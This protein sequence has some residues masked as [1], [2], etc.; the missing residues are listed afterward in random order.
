MAAPTEM[1]NGEPESSSPFGLVL[2]FRVAHNPSRLDVK[3][4]DHFLE[5]D[6]WPHHCTFFLA[7]YFRV[8]LHLFAF[9]HASTNTPYSSAGRAHNRV[10]NSS[11]SMVIEEMFGGQH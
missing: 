5:A 8:R 6:F 11:W 9:M 1:R 7:D 4:G 2:N 3:D 10:P